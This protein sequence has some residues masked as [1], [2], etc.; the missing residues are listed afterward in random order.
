MVVPTATTISK[1]ASG[2]MG[3]AAA[4][5]S[6][7]FPPSRLPGSLGCPLLRNGRFSSRWITSELLKITG[8]NLFAPYFSVSALKIKQFGRLFSA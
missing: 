4:G 2:T 3:P 5:P 1:R 7:T 8:P 6:S